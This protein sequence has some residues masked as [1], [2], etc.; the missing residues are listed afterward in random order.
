MTISEIRS[1]MLC[2][3][4]VLETGKCD[5]FECV[6]KTFCDNISRVVLAHKTEEK[7]EVIPEE[8]Q[9]NII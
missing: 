9:L 6:K 7:V 1:A 2:Y 5:C 8:K 3:T 4:G